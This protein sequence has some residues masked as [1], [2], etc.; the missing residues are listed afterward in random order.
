MNE[1]PQDPDILAAHLAAVHRALTADLA[2]LVV[3]EKAMRLRPPSSLVSGTLSEQDLVLLEQWGIPNVEELGFAPE[4][5]GTLVE[6]AGS[7]V[8]PFL[9]IGVYWRWKIG[10][11]GQGD[12][13]GLQLEEWPDVF[14]NSSVNAFVETS[15]RWYHTWLE[16]KEMGWYIEVFDVL[17]D[18][19]EF[20]TLRDANVGTN[21]RSLWKF[22]VRSMSG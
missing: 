9:R 18:F 13:R 11:T 7:P 1:R 8:D 3:P 10:V 21:E 19:L 4:A 12:I 5:G 2:E 16:A 14:V 15:W 20:A 22:I 17:D 6:E